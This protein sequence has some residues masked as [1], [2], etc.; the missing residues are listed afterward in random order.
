MSR[1]DIA[2]I[3]DRLSLKYLDSLEE[4]ACAY[5]QAVESNRAIKNHPSHA[6]IC[7]EIAANHTQQTLSSHL[8]GSSKQDSQQSHGSGTRS[9][10]S[11]PAGSSGGGEGSDIIDSSQPWITIKTQTY[12]RQLTVR[13][14]SLELDGLVRQCLGEFF[15]VCSRLLPPAQQVYIKYSDL[16]WI[17]AALWL[18]A[19]SRN[20]AMDLAPGASSAPSGAEAGSGAGTEAKTGAKQTSAKK[21][22]GRGSK[23]LKEMIMNASDHSVKLQ[24]L[25]KAIDLIEL[26]VPE[27]LKSLRKAKGGKGSRTSAPSTPKKQKAAAAPVRDQD[28]DENMAVDD[29]GGG[30]GS[31]RLSLDMPTTTTTSRRGGGTRDSS[32]YAGL[33]AKRQISNVSMMSMMSDDDDDGQDDQQDATP[34]PEASAARPSKRKKMDTQ[35]PETKVAS[36]SLSS[37]SADIM[38]PTKK[39]A[40]RSLTEATAAFQDSSRLQSKRKRTGGVYSMIPRT[41]YED[42]KAYAHYQEWRTRI[43]KSIQSK[44]CP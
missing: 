20:M 8:I 25:D 6:A 41:R 14:G 15:P 5:L 10:G 43:L 23:E 44:G 40:A 42:T 29:G 12:L 11:Q 27:Y 16:K 19:M 3:L 21:I 13:Y 1:R 37:S 38:N 22:G 33:S 35:G 26:F 30:A 32:A 2:E 39:A 34:A 31:I 24:E 36:S 17:G 28:G 7:V 4:K 18:C 9:H